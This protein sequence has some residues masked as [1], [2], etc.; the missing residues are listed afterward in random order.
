MSRATAAGLL[1]I[2]GA[3][4]GARFAS[5]PLRWACLALAL[6]YAAVTAGYLTATAV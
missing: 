3:F 4:P 6:I 1:H 5:P 2:W